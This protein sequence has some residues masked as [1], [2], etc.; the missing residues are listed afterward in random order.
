[1]SAQDIEIEP[2]RVG[3]E[4]LICGRKSFYC[5]YFRSADELCYD[6]S[7]PRVVGCLSGSRPNR[8]E[9]RAGGGM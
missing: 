5:N 7:R 9:T 4:G 1:M 3:G 6:A 8:A 2:D